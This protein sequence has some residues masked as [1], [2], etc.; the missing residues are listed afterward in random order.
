MS[1]LRDSLKVRDVVLGIAYTLDIDSLCLLVN[2]SSDILRLVAVDKLGVDAKT[3]EENLELVV[4]A[5]VEIGRRDDVVASMGEGADCEELS[6]LTRRGCKS[7]DTTFESGYSLLKDV[8]CWL[9][10]R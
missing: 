7:S 10:R 5:A 8:D 1:S 3:G 2:S 6:G 9:E 4:S